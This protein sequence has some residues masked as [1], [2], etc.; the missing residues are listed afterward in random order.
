[1]Q[2]VNLFKRIER[3]MRDVNFSFVTSLIELKINFTPQQFVPGLI[4]FK[5]L[6]ISNKKLPTGSQGI[7]RIGVAGLREF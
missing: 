5:E 4:L 3:T 1:M 2:L 6:L 7:E